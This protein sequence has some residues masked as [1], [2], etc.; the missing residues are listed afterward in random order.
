[1]G[2][3]TSQRRIDGGTS[4]YFYAWSPDATRV[5]YLGNAP[6]GSGVALG[7]VDVASGTA[8]LIDSGQPYYLDW[9]AD[10]SRLAIHANRTD[11]FYVDLDGTRTDIDAVPGLFQAPAVLP[12]GR[13]LILTGGPE[14]GLVAL[15]EDGG[16]TV[17]SRIGGVSF[18]AASPDG[19]RVAFTD[20][21]SGDLLGPLRMVSTSGG[22]P[23]YVTPESVAAFQWAPTGTALMFLGLDDAR[24]GLIPSVWDGTDVMIYEP[25]VPSS[26]FLAS[27]LPFWD[28]YSRVLSIWSPDGASF[29]LPVD[30]GNILIYTIDEPTPR[31]LTE[32]EFASWSGGER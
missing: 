19:S 3:D 20:N 28:Q 5:A 4:P 25:I 29:L 6:D 21:S 27:Y 13:L 14:P 22:E 30:G 23:T 31:R 10:S 1:M 18:F 9:S 2:S 17:L 16:E 26:T 32:G 7:M 24:S 12:D 11:L 15:A 8:E